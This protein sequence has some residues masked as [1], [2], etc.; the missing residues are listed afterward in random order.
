MRKAFALAR[1]DAN[2]YF[3]SW[4]GAFAFA[5]FFLVA[6][7]LFSIVVMTYSKISLDV[8]K[9]Y[10]ETQGLGLTRFIWGSFF[11]NIGAVLIF[12]APILSMRAFAEERKQQTLELLFTYPLSDFDIVSGK[13]LGMV[14]FFE[15]L[16]LPTLA[17]TA[18]LHWLG[19]EPDWGPVLVGFLGFWLLGLAYLSLGL[20][21]SSLTDNPVVSA[22]V[23]F[24]LLLVFWVLEWVVS[25][26]DGPS[27]RLL[28]LLSPLN[29][30]Q[31]FTVG[32]LDLSNVVYFVCFQLYFIFL[33]MRSIE[34]RNWK[35]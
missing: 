20:F 30:Y 9:G 26:A 1:K 14:W 12:L 24:G 13:F 8:S 33:A 2:A 34:A 6:G 5:F 18:L 16:F 27:A 15:A 21:V 28:A 3:Q 25:I 10:Q 23:T 22:I 11:A 35:G 29:H 17:Y 19:V 4:A 31:E 7:I 32:I